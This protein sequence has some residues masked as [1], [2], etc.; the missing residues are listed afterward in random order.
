MRVMFDTQ[1]TMDKFLAEAKA[2]GMTPQNYF[3]HL[4]RLMR[5]KDELNNLNADKE[6]AGKDA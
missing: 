5:A 6:P 1:A 3:A 4:E 2:A